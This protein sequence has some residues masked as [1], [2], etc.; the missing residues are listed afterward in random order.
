MIYVIT[1]VHNRIDITKDFVLQLKQQTYCEGIHL[2]L[3]DDGSTDGTSQMV[4]QEYPDSTILKGNGNLWWGGAMHV[5]YQWVAENL[6]GHFGDWLLLTNDDVEYPVDYID[7]A[8]GFL[9][10]HTRTLLLGEGYDRDTGELDV[11]VQH[12]DYFASKKQ[13]M[14]KNLSWQG[15]CC[16]TRSLFMR[17]GDF[18]SI[19]GFH[20]VL[21]PHYGSDYEWTYRANKKGYSIISDSQI[22]YYYDKKTTGDNDYEKLNLKKV[23]SK[24]SMVNPWYKFVYIV[25]TT[26]PRFLPQ[27]LGQQLFRYIQKAGLITKIVF[28]RE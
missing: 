7:R 25:M 5:A 15:D 6:M 1:A 19:G 24:R 20:P 9:K 27:E 8:T 16:A 28:R 17:V 13:D 23:F 14:K 18:I 10:K 4:A 22:Y 11:V 3:V 2:I 12:Y 26:P 21:L